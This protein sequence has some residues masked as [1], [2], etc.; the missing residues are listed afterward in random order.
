MGICCS[1]FKSGDDEEENAQEL[2]LQAQRAK[3]A[4]SISAKMS[5]PSIRASALSVEGEGLALVGA[6]LDQDA[7]YWEWHITTNG[8]SIV[9]GIHFGVSGKK[10]RTF[11][12]SPDSR[13]TDDKGKP[14]QSATCSLPV[15]FVIC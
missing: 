3:K 13:M 1:C 12:E 2:E 10:D 11:Y 6:S 8:K 5:A 9:D 4:L 7:A 14:N 15:T